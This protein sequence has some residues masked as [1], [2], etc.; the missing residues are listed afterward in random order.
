M[1]FN[2]E[3]HTS[4]TGL[5]N[6]LDNLRY[7]K[8]DSVYHQKFHFMYNWDQPPPGTSC[9]H[10]DRVSNIELTPCRE[11]LQHQTQTQFHRLLCLVF[12]CTTFERPDVLCENRRNGHKSSGMGCASSVR[13]LCLPIARSAVCERSVLLQVLLSTVTNLSL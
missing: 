12:H 6:I 13:C 3:H 2:A 10:S 4:E 9:V 5:R 8:G 1:Q 7:L 11:A